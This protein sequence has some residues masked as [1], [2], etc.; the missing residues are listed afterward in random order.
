MGSRARHALFHLLF[1]FDFEKV[2]AL[3]ALEKWILHGIEVEI[4]KL[5]ELGG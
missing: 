5:L 4:D 1:Y 2:A 3:L